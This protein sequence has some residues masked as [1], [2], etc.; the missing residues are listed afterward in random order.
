M[1]SETEEGVGWEFLEHD[2]HIHSRFLVV[3]IRLYLLGVTDPHLIWH[4]SWHV[5]HSI[6]RWFV[7]IVLRQTEHLSF[8]GYL[9]IGGPGFGEMSPLVATLSSWKFEVAFE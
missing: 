3:F 2:G 6:A 9:S 8:L 7:A 5:S 4:H 1:A